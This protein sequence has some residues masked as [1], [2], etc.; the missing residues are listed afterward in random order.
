MKKI[1]Q[2]LF[3]LLFC[4]ASNVAVERNATSNLEE[5]LVVDSLG[6]YIEGIETDCPHSLQTLVKEH[7]FEDMFPVRAGEDDARVVLYIAAAHAMKCTNTALCVAKEFVENYGRHVL[8][9]HCHVNETPNKQNANH[10]DM[11]FK[12]SFYDFLA[13]LAN[14]YTSTNDKHSITH[15]ETDT[16]LLHDKGGDVLEQELLRRLDNEIIYNLFILPVHSTMEEKEIEIDVFG[17]TIRL[18]LSYHESKNELNTTR[19]K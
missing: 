8:P 7:L 6:A 15:S 17:G 19:A 2:Y 12:L 5:S 9:I 16:I 14:M 11:E 4:T 1:S 18:E 13:K 10:E 3:L